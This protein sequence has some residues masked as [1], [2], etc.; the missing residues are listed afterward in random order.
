MSGTME[1]RSMEMVV[2]NSAGVL[3]RV[4]ALFGRQGYNIDELTVS[5][6]GDDGFYKLI[7][8]TQGDPV[9]M[10]QMVRQA[11]RLVEVHSARLEDAAFTLRRE[12]LLVTLEPNDQ[13]RIE[14]LELCKSYRAAIADITQDSLVLEMTGSPDQTAD[15]LTRLHSYQ[16]GRAHV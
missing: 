7:I 3:A 6:I 11:R 8:T 13:Q 1:K 15:F 4:A 16:I 14:I 12:L 9:I 10:E 5:Q 2:E